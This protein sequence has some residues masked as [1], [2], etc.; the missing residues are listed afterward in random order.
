MSTFGRYILFLIPLISLI[1]C[2]KILLEKDPVNDPVTNFDYLWEDV[3]NRYSFFELKEINWPA[4]RDQYRPQIRPE[5]TD[6]QLFDILSDM[7][8]E[9]RDGHV[10]LTSSFDRSR[11]WDWFWEYPPNFNRHIVDRSYL[12]KDFMITGPL[13]N[14][15][16]DS[17]LY[18]Y[19]ESFTNTITDAHLNALMERAKGL[20]GV[21]I[22]VR[23]NGGGNLS[24]AYR[25]ASCFTEQTVSFGKERIK[26][27]PGSSDFTD[28]RTL[29]VEPRSGSKFTGKVMVLTN[30]VCYSATNH[31]AQMM[32]TL[33]NATLIGDQTGGGGGIPASGQLPNGWIYRLS[34]T[35]TTDMEGYQLELGIPPD[36]PVN[37]EESDIA[38]DK[39]T[40]IERALSQLK[41]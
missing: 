36:I 9:L 41:Q 10:N 17:I 7:L 20:K 22:D 19:Y 39:D 21:I 40:I 28:W 13:L 3:Q 25:L 4:I 29:R 37:M 14:Q 38:E 26:S 15:V 18:V 5:L 12:K 1:S 6:R 35:Q 32:K 8:Y 2:E 24:N 27:G 33:P 30:R 34:V 23:N 11:N 31:F 16:I